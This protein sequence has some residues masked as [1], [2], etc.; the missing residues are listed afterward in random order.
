MIYQKFKANESEFV[1]TIEEWI[2]K[3]SKDFTRVETP[4]EIR[5]T[6][7]QGEFVKYKVANDIRD[8]PVERCVEIGNLN[9]TAN[10]WLCTWDTLCE[11]FYYKEN[12]ECMPHVAELT[13]HVAELIE[14]LR[15]RFETVYEFHTGK[16]DRWD[17]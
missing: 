17:D 2:Q 1:S 9:T 13:P 14:T 10:G 6:N 8:M 7:S 15:K 3:H 5:W 16:Y 4:G 12:F 11:K